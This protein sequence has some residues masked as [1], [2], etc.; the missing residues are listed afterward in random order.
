VACVC[1]TIQNRLTMC[2]IRHTIA[3]RR[4]W[5]LPRLRSALHML[6]TCD[7]LCI[8]RRRRALSGTQ[9]LIKFNASLKWSAMHYSFH[10][11]LTVQKSAQ[12]IID[13][14]LRCKHGAIINTSEPMHRPN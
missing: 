13:E 9:R 8:E 1:G 4:R 11:L 14:I 3:G 5:S 12:C 10:V 2:G 7:A 6:N